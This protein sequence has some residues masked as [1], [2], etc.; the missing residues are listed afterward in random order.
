[1]GISTVFFALITL[2]VSYIVSME[3]LYK[4]TVSYIVNMEALY[5][6]EENS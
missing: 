5:Q 6:G 2:G 4:M 3:E 1:V